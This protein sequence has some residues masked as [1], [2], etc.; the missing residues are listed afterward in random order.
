MQNVT[1]GVG[2]PGPTTADFKPGVAQRGTP[3]TF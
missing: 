1:V 2:A 3:T